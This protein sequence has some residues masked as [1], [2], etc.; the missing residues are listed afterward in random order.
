MSTLRAN[1][2]E[3]TGGKVLVRSSGGI[4]NVTQLLNT[5]QSAVSNAANAVLWTTSVNKLYDASSTNLVVHAQLN[6]RV[7][8]SGCCGTY[9]EIGGIR[10]YNFVHEYNDWTSSEMPIWGMGIWTGLGVGSISVVA[11]WSTA[12][13]SATDRPFATFNPGQGVSDARSRATASTIIVYEV[14]I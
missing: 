5:T 7:Q 8:S 3:T 11:G 1:Q 13:G 14:V 10:N 9:L 12:N 4:I 2:I 6:G